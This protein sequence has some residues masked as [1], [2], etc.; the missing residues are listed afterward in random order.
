MSS[1]LHAVFTLSATSSSTAVW[2]SLCWRSPRSPVTSNCTGSKE[3]FQCIT[4]HQPLS[5]S[6]WGT[7][8]SWFSCSL[9]QFLPS[10]QCRRFVVSATFKYWYSL[11]SFLLC[12]WIPL[13]NSCNLMAPLVH[14]D[15]P[16]SSPW[17]ETNI[18]LFYLFHRSVQSPQAQHVPTFSPNCFL[19]IFSLSWRHHQLPKPKT[20]QSFSPLS[21]LSIQNQVLPIYI[22]NISVTSAFPLYL[23]SYCTCS[24]IISFSQLF[25]HT[26]E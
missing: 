15:S 7:P 8:P 9:W 20:W 10:L 4:S 23:W 5:L 2:F 11:A 6:S 12:L 3:A 25:F 21:F 16:R 1:S 24:W 18:Q 17:D 22:I 19:Y 14:D 13:V 26:T